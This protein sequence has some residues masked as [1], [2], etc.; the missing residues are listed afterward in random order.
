MKPQLY[1]KNNCIRMLVRGKFET[2]NLE[3]IPV[4]E[5]P[6]TIWCFTSAESAVLTACGLNDSDKTTTQKK[7]S[8]AQSPYR[9]SSTLS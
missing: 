5:P 1:F 2:E 6:K 7:R 9:L 8:V 4:A 3:T